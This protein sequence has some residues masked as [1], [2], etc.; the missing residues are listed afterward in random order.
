MNIMVDLETMGTQHNAAI[1]SI[2]AVVFDKDKGLGE[3]FYTAVALQSCARYGLTVTPNTIMWWLKQGQE[4]RDAITADTAV[5]IKAALEAFTE[6]AR[7]QGEEGAVIWGNGATFDNVILRSA[8][9][10]TQLPAPWKFWNDRCYRTLKGLYP[11]VKLPD[12]GGVHHN[13]L[14]DAKYQAECAIKILRSIK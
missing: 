4:A 14:D 7:R 10:Q 13:A 9:E 3:E 11:E 12:R 1:V 5:D 6:F 2:G 8:Y